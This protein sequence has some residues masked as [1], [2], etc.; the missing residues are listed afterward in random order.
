MKTEWRFFNGPR[1]APELLVWLLAGAT[2]LVVVLGSVRQIERAEQQAQAQARSHLANLSRLA[3][4]HAV[5]T[6][7]A[8]DQA[9]QLVRTLYLREGARLRLADWVASGAID[10]A[11]FHQV[12][13]IDAQ[14]IYRLSNRA[15]TPPV[16][17]SDRAHFR[18]HIDTAQDTL[19]VSQPVLGRVSKRWT[20][21][22]TRRISDAQGRFAGVAVLSLDADY[23]NRFYDQL[24]LGPD[25][26][27]ALVGRDG[28]VRARRGQPADMRVVAPQGVSALSLQAQGETAGFFARASPLD[29]RWRLHHFRTLPGFDL[30]VTLGLT[31]QRIDPQAAQRR[32]ATWLRTGLIVALLGT[33]AGLYSWQRRREWR[34]LQA[35]VAEKTALGLALDSG[36]MGTWAWDLPTGRLNVDERL[37]QLLGFAPGELSTDSRHFWERI[38]PDDGAAFRTA[39]QPVLA[40]PGARLDQL[41]RLRH[42][43]GHW[44]W[45]LAR[46]TVVARSSD[47]RPL[48][49]VGVDVDQS[50]QVA[51]EAERRIAEVA[52][53][54]GVA[55]LVSD[56]HRVVLRSNAAFERL[57]GYSPAQTRGQSANLLRSGLHDAA[58]YASIDEGLARNGAWDG[59]LWNRR[60]NGTLYLDWMTVTA[61]YDAQGQAQHYVAVHRDITDLDANALAALRASSA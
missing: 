10:A 23:F 39:L 60:K 45:L 41:H 25:G 48:R 8:A 61:V 42:K 38:H 13:V 46:G 58:F 26:L 37:R 2:A 21:Q 18:V 33:L 3:Q 53:E 36:G 40:Q 52:F 44:V 17:L 6:L 15:Q 19:Y 47:G 16:D 54:V 20:L 43:D 32:S 7:H 12:G 35:V 34:N 29:A 56:A 1:W 11:L 5:R 55:M 49:L 30:H 22:L 24:D 4:E 31:P 14:G 27:A 28:V 51:Q 59:Q 57:S 9:L 50:A